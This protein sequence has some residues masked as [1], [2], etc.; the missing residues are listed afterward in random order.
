[1]AQDLTSDIER[2][3]AATE[4]D[5][6]KRGVVQFETLAERSLQNPDSNSNL[7]EVCEAATQAIDVDLLKKPTSLFWNCPDSSVREWLGDDAFEQLSPKRLVVVAPELPENLR[8]KSGYADLSFDVTAR[9]RVKNIVVLASTNRDY[10][11]LAK[12][13]A[14]TTIYKPAEFNGKPFRRSGVTWRLSF[15]TE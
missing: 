2:A 4:E 10:A 6:L 5:G 3:I 15:S 1:M 9:G 13:V 11:N 14:R 7:V 8:G 12:K